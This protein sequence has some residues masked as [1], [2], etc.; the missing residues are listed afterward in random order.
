MTTHITV[1]L[2][3]HNNGWNGHICQNP[4]GNTYCVGRH[5]YPGDLIST[6][7]DTEWEIKLDVA[8]KPCS[9]VNGIPACAYSINAFGDQHMK[10]T[11]DPPVWFYDDSKGV[12]LDIPPATV[13]TW[14]YE[15]MYSDD[16][17]NRSGSGQKFDYEY[18]LKKAKDYFAKLEPSKSLLFYYAN[19]SNPFSEDDKPL[20]VLIGISR[21]KE[22]GKIHYYDNVSEE[23]KMKYAGGFVWQMPLHHTIQNKDSGFHTRSIWTTPKH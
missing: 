23:N 10:A 1:R 5:S 11:A 20:Y 4:K 21:L 18:R 15:A 12:L 14:P 19:Y 17:Q 13:C 3:W 22:T 9:R 6:A 2:A 7:R 8:G 16:V